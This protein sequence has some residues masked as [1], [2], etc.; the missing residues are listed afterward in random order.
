MYFSKKKSGTFSSTVLLVCLFLL[1]CAC[2]TKLPEKQ[3]LQGNAFGTTFAI[4]YFTDIPLHLEKGVDSVIDAVNRSVSTYQ[5]D[6]DISRINN[7]DSTVVVDAIFS[8]VYD[9]SE[10]VYTQSSGYFDPTIGV[11]RNAYG[12][13]DEQ[14]I[15][16]IDQKVLDSLMRFVGFQKVRLLEDGTIRKADPAIYFDFNAVAKGYGIDLIGKYLEDQGIEN[17]LIELGGELLARGKNLARDQRW[18]AGVEAVDSEVWQRSTEAM[19]ALDNRAMAAS[20]NY[21]KFRI[22]SATGRKYVH[23]INP[24]TGEAQQSDVTS[25]TVI[26]PNCTLADAYATAFMAM[27]LERSKLL[28][29]KLKEVDAYLTYADSLSPSN[30]FMTHGFEMSL[31]LPEIPD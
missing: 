22:D 6:S 17:Y 27:G 11:L 2:E 10:Q 21:R 5:K 19:V 31:L 14:P 30:I 4:Q 24:L 20:G 1:V 28:L 26:A 18:V 23:T 8:H 12:F 15:E 7:G 13:G 3:V 25:A 16:H 9:I 29:T